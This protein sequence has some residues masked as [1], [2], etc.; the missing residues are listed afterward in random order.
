[1]NSR[2]SPTT[3]SQDGRTLMSP[4]ECKIARCTQNQIE[5]RPISLCLQ[6]NPIGT[7]FAGYMFTK[8]FYW[9]KRRGLFTGCILI[10]WLQVTHPTT[11][12]ETET[13]VPAACQPQPRQPH[14]M[15]LLLEGRAKGGQ[16]TASSSQLLGPGRGRPVGLALPSDLTPAAPVF[17]LCSEWKQIVG[18]LR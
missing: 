15:D 17:V 16:D 10:G 13:Q 11:S 7:N 5:M 12:R 1:M 3:L 4:Q 9:Y 8:H 18:S 2:E 6:S 14:T